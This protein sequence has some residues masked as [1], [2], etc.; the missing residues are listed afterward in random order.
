MY[1]L[2]GPDGLV[3]LR[4]RKASEL[5]Q[6]KRIYEE[7]NNL[8]LRDRRTARE[9]GITLEQ[10]DSLAAVVL[11]GTDLTAAR[12]RTAL[13]LG[14]GADAPL[15]SL[16]ENKGKGGKGRSVSG[17][18]S[19]H[20]LAHVMAGAKALPLW[21]AMAT[22]RREALFELLATND[23]LDDVL[24]R[25]QSDFG[26]DEALAGKLAEAEL[27]AGRGAAGP[28]ATARLC[29]SLKAAVISNQEAEVACGLQAL[30]GHDGLIVSA[31]PYYGELFP[32]ACVGGTGRA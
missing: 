7:L 9:F 20:P 21:A 27:P 25:L 26:F 22:E 23:D 4:V 8:R 6:T 14:K 30:T 19:A 29:E 2:R 18:V 16:E 31:L 32:L 28:T 17:S 5:F 24:C 11:E 1:G 15:T 12:L 3:E 10:R 13:K